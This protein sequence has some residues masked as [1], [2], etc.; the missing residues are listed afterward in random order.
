[1]SIFVFFVLAVIAAAII[2]YPML[3]G[4]APAQP[5]TVLTDGEIEQA[6]HALRRSRSGGGLVCPSC[7]RVAQTGDLFCVRCGTGLPESQVQ[8]KAD[9]LVCYSCG[10]KLHAVDQFCAKC[11]HP[12]GTEEA[13]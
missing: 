1:M 3:P 13:E 8:P 6:V 4:R 7:G 10:A 9:D 5:A 11:G 12:V 2:A